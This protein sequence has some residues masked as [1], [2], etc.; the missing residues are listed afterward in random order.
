MLKNSSILQISAL[1][2]RRI[3]LGVTGSI[4]A[5]KSAFLARLLVQN[6]AEVRVILTK[7]AEKF[8]GAATFE[9]ITNA[10][11]LTESG[12]SWTNG[13]NHI[14]FAKWGELFIVA[15]ATANTIAKL[16]AGIGDNL[17]L[18]TFLACAAPKIIA[19]AANINM[20]TNAAITRAITRLKDD[21]FCIANGDEGFLACGDIGG[22]RMIEPEKL[23]FVAA[24][25]LAKREFWLGREVIVSGG[26]T[27]EQIDA[28]RTIGN[29][30]S[31]KMALSL[32]RAAYLLG[33]SVTL[34]GSVNCGD[35]DI[36]QI[37]AKTIAE[38]DI[39]LET[40][41]KNS[42]K[43]KLPVL[44][45]AAAVSDF[46][47]V[48]KID[49]KIKK[50]EV[51]DRWTLEMK[52]AKDILSSIDKS[53]IYSVGFKAETDENSAMNWAQEMK[54]SKSLNAV[55]LNILNVGGVCFGSDITKIAFIGKNSY[56]FSGAKSETAFNILDAIEEDNV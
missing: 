15:P 10:E 32:C 53:E 43:S 30:S 2:N 21:G 8:I 9:A 22:G 49:R 18:Q 50:T 52:K 6:G 4:A 47:P 44:L 55:C 11:V 17:L 16:A 19:P 33:A 26:G 41:I 23:I 51:G 14:S 56:E 20:L 24:R 29:L 13:L 7:K 40:A 31:G 45:M 34:I 39:E 5:Y 12:E 36:K 3:L 38:M 37:S 48:E 25:E 1:K 42:D 28:A 54:K 46:I 35:L 27:T